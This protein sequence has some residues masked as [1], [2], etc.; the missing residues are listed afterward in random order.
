M[1]GDILLITSYF[2][3]IYLGEPTNE[4]AS[5]AAMRLIG[6]GYPAEKLLLVQGELAF[7]SG[8]RVHGVRSVR[9]TEYEPDDKVQILIGTIQVL[10]RIRLRKD[11][12]VNVMLKPPL[13][14]VVITCVAFPV[15]FP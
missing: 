2:S 13:S 5:Q 7:A 6:K 4:A 15:H 9:I 12:C 8:P 1:F 14:I 11:R 10:A 3:S